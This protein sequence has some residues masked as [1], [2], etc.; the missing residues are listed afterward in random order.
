M[1]SIIVPIYN[2]EKYIADC[3]KSLINQTYSD[4]EIILVDDGSTDNSSN[5][6][7]EYAAKDSRVKVIHKK[8]GG[9]VSARKMGI[10]VATGELIAY[11]DGDDWVEPDMYEKLNEK[12]KA[13]NVDIVICA[14]Y[15]DTKDI[16]KEVYQGFSEGKYDKKKLLSE[17]Y[18]RM[19]VNDLFF[20]W[21]INSSLCDKLFKK[22]LILPYQLGVNDSIAWGEDA[23]CVYPSLLKA[24]SIYIYQKCLYHYRQIPN[25]MSKQIPNYEEEKCKY[26]IM[27]RYTMNKLAQ[28]IAIYDLREQ[29]T[30][31]VLFLMTARADGLYEGYEK[32]NYL[33]P[34]KSVKKNE[35]IVLYGAGTYGR[36]LYSYLMRTSFCTVVLWADK[37]YIELQ[38]EGL[39]VCGPECIRDCNYDH[40]V[41]AITYAKARQGAVK[42]L[43]QKYGYERVE[44]IDVGLIISEE[45]K[46]NF[47]LN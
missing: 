19:I 10:L 44:T 22:E 3:I 33:Y 40:I 32:L 39:D 20:E 1:I 27:Y 16:R 34:F 47:G 38:K 37:N 4:L 31:Y 8:N 43:N 9:L 7:D 6:C 24:D 11:V 14:R 28:D 41:V 5:I 18:P 23:A 30:K 15:E 21:G 45:S 42:A 13:E 12:V 26:Q 29:W 35:K 17:I 25:S 2:V 36:R 46:K